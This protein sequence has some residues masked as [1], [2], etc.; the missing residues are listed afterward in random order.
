MKL[1]GIGISVTHLG[2]LLTLAHAITLFN[3]ELTIVR[4]SSEIG[5]V[6]LNND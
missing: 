5:V 3:Q 1:R 6:M 4:I 2:N